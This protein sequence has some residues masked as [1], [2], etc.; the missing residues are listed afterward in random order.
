MGLDRFH[1]ELLFSPGLYPCFQTEKERIYENR[2]KFVRFLILF[3]TDVFSTR[4][5]NN[6]KHVQKSNSSGKNSDASDKDQPSEEPS[7]KESLSGSSKAALEGFVN[8]RSKSTDFPSRKSPHPKSRVV[9]PRIQPQTNTWL[10]TPQ[11]KSKEELDDDKSDVLSTGEETTSEVTP[12]GQRESDDD[13]VGHS[14]NLVVL[15]E[16]DGDLEDQLARRHSPHRKRHATGDGQNDTSTEKLENPA[17]F[18]EQKAFQGPVMK[19]M[20][21]ISCNY[22]P[23]S[24]SVDADE[25]ERPQSR[26]IKNLLSPDDFDESQATVGSGRGWFFHQFTTKMYEFRK[27]G[28]RFGDGDKIGYGTANWARNN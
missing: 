2:F 26:Q 9:S 18:V 23:R 3:L 16:V 21:D 17:I 4:K 15:G 11:S 20:S 24:S 14:V 22:R 1:I 19:S 13:L 10:S 6:N 27:M 12:D 7:R 28:Q 8:H 5:T 25:D